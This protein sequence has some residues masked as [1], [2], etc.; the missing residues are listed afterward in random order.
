VLV[1]ESG[2][3]RRTNY[4]TVTWRREF[5][6]EE[7]CLRD[8]WAERPFEQSVNFAINILYFQTVFVI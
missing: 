5:P 2:S 6:G 4:I 7:V 3:S 8:I 1:T